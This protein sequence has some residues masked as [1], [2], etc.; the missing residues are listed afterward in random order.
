MITVR[1]SIN[2]NERRKW[3]CFQPNEQQF[4]CTHKHTHITKVQAHFAFFLFSV[5][6]ALH[7]EIRIYRIFLISHIFISKQ[8]LYKIQYSYLLSISICIMLLYTHRRHGIRDCYYTHTLTIGTDVLD[9]PD[10]N[11]W[12][13]IMT[14]ANL[15][16]KFICLST[17]FA[18]EFVRAM[19]HL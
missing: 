18:G 16:L 3:R 19:E 12:Q 5:S 9:V 2:T 6:E 8:M 7:Y 10:E 1:F 14:K 4:S 17:A 13:F 11:K 15:S